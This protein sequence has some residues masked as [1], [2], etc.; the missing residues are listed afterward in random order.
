MLRIIPDGVR[1]AGWHGGKAWDHFPQTCPHPLP[2]P[3]FLTLPY[4][5][6]SFLNLSIVAP[7]CPFDFLPHL[8][9]TISF[10]TSHL[11]LPTS[12]CPWPSPTTSF[13]L[14]KQ[15]LQ[16]VGPMC[17]AEA[18]GALPPP[19]FSKPPH[20]PEGEASDRAL[21]SDYTRGAGL[22]YSPEGRQLSIS[23]NCRERDTHSCVCAHTHA[24]S[25]LFFPTCSFVN[26]GPIT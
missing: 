14:S 21:P 2:S 18:N 23:D 13:C 7:R 12:C 3:L 5:R 4:F 25:L 11:I 16:S 22:E 10:S 15:L 6:F 26:Q 9:L 17:K 1:Q 20:S 8:S 24:D 19:F